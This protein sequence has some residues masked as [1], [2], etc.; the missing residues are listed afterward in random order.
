MPV[1]HV[2]ERCGERRRV[3]NTSKA[4]RAS[5]V[6][7][8]VVEEEVRRPDG[9]LGGGE[10]TCPDAVVGVAPRRRPRQ[11]ASVGQDRDQLAAVL[12][13]LGE[14]LRRELL[15][16]ALVPDSLTGERQLDAELLQP[17]Q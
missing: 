9:A 14:E 12:L 4:N 10:R 8:P 3:E 13:H 6:V 17:L 1:M 5:E 7:R 15:A 11:L 2:A 16:P